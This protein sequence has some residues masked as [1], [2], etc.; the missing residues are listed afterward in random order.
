MDVGD[1]R[2]Y[3]LKGDVHR[4][5]GDARKIGKKRAMTKLKID[6]KTTRNTTRQ[7]ITESIRELNNATAASMPSEKSL[8]RMVKRYRQKD[9]VPKNPTN[10]SELILPEEYR[11]TIKGGDFLLFD[12]HDLSEDE[13]RMLIFGTRQNLAFL[14][15]C[16]HIYMDG[17]FTVVPVLF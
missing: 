4:H 5:A 17:T 3:I 9:G 13:E 11:K 14:A 10:A 15:Q 8:V 6:A 12:S 16:D 7:I 2:H 1:P